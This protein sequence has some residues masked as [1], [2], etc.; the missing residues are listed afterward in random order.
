MVVVHEVAAGYG[1]AFFVGAE[2][3]MDFRAGT[4]GTCIAHFPEVVVLV[5][6]DYM[7]GRKVLFPNGRSFVVAA[8]SF[9]RR[10]FEN[11]SIQ[12]FWVEMQYVD[13]IFPCPVDSFLL[14]IIAK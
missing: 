9:F 12:A 10:T 3:D 4:A 6:V 13:E 11:G 5:A 7:I 1:G 2:V 8:E 14:E